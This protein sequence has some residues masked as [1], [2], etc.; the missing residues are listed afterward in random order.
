MAIQTNQ[1]RTHTRVRAAREILL[2]FNPRVYTENTQKIT[3]ART[4]PGRV[5]YFF[6]RG[7]TMSGPAVFFPIKEEQLLRTVII[8][9]CKILW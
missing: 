8:L 6:C 5:I 1:V 9:F 2:A 3:R 7:R 4:V